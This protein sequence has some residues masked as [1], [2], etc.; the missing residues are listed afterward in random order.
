MAESS[1]KPDYVFLFKCV[2]QTRLGIRYRMQEVFNFSADE[3]V[4]NADTVLAGC[5]RPMRAMDL[6]AQSHN[7]NGAD[8]EK[9][10]LLEQSFFLDIAVTIDQVIDKLRPLYA[11]FGFVVMLKG[12]T[13]ENVMFGLLNFFN[14][15]NHLLSS[16]HFP[17]SA[18]LL[19]SFLR[20]KFKASPERIIDVF[21]HVLTH[22]PNYYSWARC[23]AKSFMGIE[24][25]TEPQGGN[26]SKII[27]KKIDEQAAIAR[28]EPK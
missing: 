19:Q 23:I 22:D 4:R 5:S 7:R 28:R 11:S 27:A 24:L 25:D 21:E 18:P 26:L 17:H 6:V 14:G 8:E 9:I 2:E 3:L 1:S 10:N 12:T 16:E 15:A 13:M 20:E